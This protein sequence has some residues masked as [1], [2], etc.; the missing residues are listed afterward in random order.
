MQDHADCTYIAHFV[1]SVATYLEVKVNN[2]L[3][4]HKI[5]SLQYLFHIEG[6]LCLVKV[7]F[8]N[9]V[10]KELASTEPWGGRRGGGEGGEGGGGR[11]GGGG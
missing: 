3:L 5:H 10:V 1:I 7:V 9:H 11:E 2:V 6:G 4:V 8:L